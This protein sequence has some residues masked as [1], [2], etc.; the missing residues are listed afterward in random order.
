MD[1]NRRSDGFKDE[2]EDESE[3]P[4]PLPSR[5]NLPYTPI[6]RAF[7]SFMTPQAKPG[8]PS[9]ANQATDARPPGGRFSLA[10][11]EARRVVVQQP[12][13]VKDIVIPPLP[14]T[15][16]SSTR[17]PEKAANSSQARNNSLHDV[18]TSPGRM[19]TPMRTPTRPILTEEERK[20]IQERR[21]SA[22]KEPPPFFPGGAPG[23]TPSKPKSSSRSSSPIKRGS[24]ELHNSPMKGHI[25][26]E[27][28]GEMSDK[29]AGQEDKAEEEEDTRS[30]L[31][32][33]KETVDQMRRR[34][35]VALGIT[36]TRAAE[37]PSSRPLFAPV[38]TPQ[39][40][41]FQ[42][43]L[44]EVMDSV[45]DQSNEVRE[46]EP[47]S[48]LRP[49]AR[50]EVVSRLTPAILEVESC[51]ENSIPLPVVVV[52][53]VFEDD[54][55]EIQDGPEVQ[56]QPM[57]TKEGQSRLLRAPKSIDVVASPNVEEEQ[58]ETVSHSRNVFLTSMS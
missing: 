33:M 39:R 38:T 44:R 1:V 42:P 45:E 6:R 17:R 20:A 53:P 26:H 31:D 2:D 9:H 12:W 8:S 21:R 46:E 25:I 58:K 22:L 23:M 51:A 29:G 50:D 49:G 19:R 27:E 28:D 30:L 52:D 56:E 47:F 54:S 4:A 41:L 57:K 34:R 48:L 35:S 3:A 40:P 16:S 7:G 13:R 43:E 14:A 18:M 15:P 36:T 11:G 24:L 10:G 55:P 32:R 5:S 37:G